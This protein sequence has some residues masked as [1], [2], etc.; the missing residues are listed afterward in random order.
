LLPRLLV[1][2]Q[3]PTK[4]VP[5]SFCGHANPGNS[6]SLSR[7]RRRKGAKAH[8]QLLWGNAAKDNFF[9]EEP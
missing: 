6:S 5:L 4:Q 9:L 8:D 2:L 7:C 3:A 1:C